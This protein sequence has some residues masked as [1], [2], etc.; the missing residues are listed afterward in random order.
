MNT[1]LMSTPDT[2][3]ILLF[4]GFSPCMKIPKSYLYKFCPLKDYTESGTGLGIK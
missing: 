1:S 2:P 4:I 3:E